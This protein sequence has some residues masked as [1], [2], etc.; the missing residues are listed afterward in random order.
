MDEDRAEAMKELAL[1]LA[2]VYES[3]NEEG[4]L[5]FVFDRV[6]VPGLRPSEQIEVTLRRTHKR[7]PL[8]MFE[9]AE[10]VESV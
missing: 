2:K 1:M 8:P 3:T 10:V 7:E 4:A 6:L 9:L 5:V